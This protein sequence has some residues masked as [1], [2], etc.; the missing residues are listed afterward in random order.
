MFTLSWPK[1]AVAGPASLGLAQPPQV[2]AKEVS[3]AVPSRSTRSTS[4][5]KI[6]GVFYVNVGVK[7][8]MRGRLTS[9][10]SDIRQTEAEIGSE[11]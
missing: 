1:W 3:G 6:G 4:Y 10:S 9:E 11:P 5:C 8:G 2:L 7:K